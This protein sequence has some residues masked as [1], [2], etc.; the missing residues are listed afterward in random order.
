MQI[1]DELIYEIRE[2]VILG[3]LDYKN[4]RGNDNSFFQDYGNSSDSN[5]NQR[6]TTT[7]S[8]TTSSS[9]NRLI[10]LEALLKKCMGEEVT[11]SF[12]VSV[13]LGQIQTMHIICR[14]NNKFVTYNYHDQ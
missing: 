10:P 8:T 11:R 4:R 9:S 12:V 7:S 1:H 14:I 13:L 6:S 3:T 2:D 5:Y